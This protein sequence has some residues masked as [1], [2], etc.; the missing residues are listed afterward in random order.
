VTSI[1]EALRTNGQDLHDRRDR[2]ILGMHFFNPV[3]RMPLVEVVVAEGTPDQEIR[4]TIAI[5]RDLGKVPVVVKDSPGFVVNR[6]LAPYLGEA[7]LLLE[8]GADPFQIDNSMRDLGFPMGPLRVLDTVGHD[9]VAHVAASL[10]GFLGERM[11]HSS[12]GALLV[13]HGH[14]G[15]KSNGGIFVAR[16]RGQKRRVAPWLDGLLKVARNK[17]GVSAGT[18]P[19]DDL[20]DRLFLSLVAEAI[21]AKNDGIVDQADALDAAMVLGAGFP[22]NLGGPLVELKRQGPDVVERRLSVLRDRYGARFSP[23]AI[24]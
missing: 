17:D 13:E 8:E 4:R 9:V 2:R 14:L 23:P 19:P 7:L 12:I 1:T 15:D 11:P 24:S 16:A 22:A 18:I 10:R 21:R 3:D 5:V 20:R 6:V